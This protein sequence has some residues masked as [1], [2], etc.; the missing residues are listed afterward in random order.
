MCECDGVGTR[1]RKTA[2]S[3]RRATTLPPKR[4]KAAEVKVE[5][6]VE[7]KTEVIVIDDD[8]DAGDGSGDDAPW[9]GEDDVAKLSKKLGVMWDKH[10]S[11]HEPI[12]AW[13]KVT[14]SERKKLERLWTG[15]VTMTDVWCEIPW[16]RQA[17]QKTWHKLCAAYGVPKDN[18]AAYGPFRYQ[19]ATIELMAHSAIE[20]DMYGRHAERGALSEE[21]ERVGECNWFLPTPSRCSIATIWCV[22]LSYSCKNT[23]Y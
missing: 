10:T 14:A 20:E 8:G 1:K 18:K 19:P 16:V 11:I 7:V 2:E 22:Y 13:E 6:K 12:A 5:V 21:A 17:T 15:E 4:A 3:V 9:T 23:G